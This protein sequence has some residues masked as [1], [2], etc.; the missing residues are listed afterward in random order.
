MNATGTYYTYM[1]M[2]QDDVMFTQ[3][4]AEETQQ[5]DTNDNT[6]TEQNVTF[7]IDTLTTSS[8]VSIVQANEVSIKSRGFFHLTDYLDTN[9]LD[10]VYTFEIEQDYKRGAQIEFR[11]HNFQPLRLSRY[12]NSSL[13]I[14]NYHF[15][16]DDTSLTKQSDSIENLSQFPRFVKYTVVDSSTVPSVSPSPVYNG[17]NDIKIEFFYDT[18]YSQPCFHT[19]AGYC[20]SQT[21]FDS[22]LSDFMI[23]SFISRTSLKDLTKIPPVIV[24]IQ[25]TLP[26]VVS[27]PA[28]SVMVQRRVKDNTPFFAS[29]LHKVITNVPIYL[30][31]GILYGLDETT[32]YNKLNVSNLKENRYAYLHVVSLDTLWSDQDGWETLPAGSCKVDNTNVSVTRKLISPYQSEIHFP[33]EI[34][35]FAV[36]IND[37]EYTENAP[38]VPTVTVDSVAFSESVLTYSASVSATDQYSSNDITMY[39]VVSTNPELPV[40]KLL[41]YTHSNTYESA[42]VSRQVSNGS[43]TFAGLT[44]SHVLDSADTVN[45]ISKV[46]SFTVYIYAVDALGLSTI[47]KETVHATKNVLVFQPH[48]TFKASTSS[49]TQISSVSISDNSAFT[50]VTKFK[51]KPELNFS[52]NTQIDLQLFEGD[53]Y[54]YSMCLNNGQLSLK[55]NTAYSSA[56][57]VNANT[58]YTVVVTFA[59]NKPVK[60]F[61]NDTELG[62][63]AVNVTTNPGNSDIKLTKML[64]NNSFV[65]EFDYIVGF[66]G[67]LEIPESQ[68]L[69]IEHFMETTPAAFA[70][71]FNNDLSDSKNALPNLNVSGVPTFNSASVYTNVAVTDSYKVNITNTSFVYSTNTFNVTGTVYSSD[72]DIKEYHMAIIPVNSFSDDYVTNKMINN[73]Y[74]SSVYK[75][76]VNVPKY[77]VHN[78]EQSMNF[79]LSNLQN[80]ESGAFSNDYYS[81]GNYTLAIVIVGESEKRLKRVALPHM[82]SAAEQVQQGKYNNVNG[83]ELNAFVQDFVLDNHKQEEGNVSSI[84]NQSN[85]TAFVGDSTVSVD[86]DGFT[87]TTFNQPFPLENS[88]QIPFT[89]DANNGFTVGMVIEV[90]N[91]NTGNVVEFDNQINLGFGGDQLKWSMMTDSAIDLPAEAYSQKLIVLWRVEQGTV[92]NKQK[93]I[94]KWINNSTTYR[95]VTS[96][97]TWTSS[98][99]IA[100]VNSY[101][102]TNNNYKLYEFRFVPA[103]VDDIDLENMETYFSN[104]YYSRNW[105]DVIG[106]W[107]LNEQTGLRDISGNDR[108]FRVPS[109]AAYS[110]VQNLFT[111]H[112]NRSCIDFGR[113]ARSGNVVFPSGNYVYNKLSNGEQW[114]NIVEGSNAFTLTFWWSVDSMNDASNTPF[115]NWGQGTNHVIKLDNSEKDGDLLLNGEYPFGQSAST[116]KTNGVWQHYAI[117]WNG[118]TTELYIDGVKGSSISSAIGSLDLAADLDALTL[119]ADLTATGPLSAL[120]SQTADI[121]NTVA[122]NSTSNARYSDIRLFRSAK[123]QEEIQSIYGHTSVLPRV[124]TLTTEIQPSYLA[125]TDAT[126]K[127]ASTTGV[128][129]YYL[130]AVNNWLF[131]P[132]ETEVKHFVHALPS[133]TSPGLKSDNTVYF[134][135]ASVSANTTHTVAPFMLTKAF[136]SFSGFESTENVSNVPGMYTTYLVSV[137]NNNE[138]LVTSSAVSNESGYLSAQLQMSAPTDSGLY[139][140]QG[141]ITNTT[142]VAVP[143]NYL[144][145]MQQGSSTVNNDVLALVKRINSQQY[146]LSSEVMHT[147]KPVSAG[148]T[149]VVPGGI[150]LKTAF[151]TADS[152]TETVIV[153]TETYTTYLVMVDRFGRVTVK[154]DIGVLNEN[155]NVELSI[156]HYPATNTGIFVNNSSTIIN[157]SNLPVAKYYVFA[158]DTSTSVPDEAQIKTFVQTQLSSVTSSSDTV[159]FNDTM[160]NVNDTHN[161]S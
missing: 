51:T 42:V 111:T 77:T 151:V 46:D 97:D 22:N 43:Q 93:G 58:W 106:L 24:D 101:R 138:L 98:D 117:V 124:H 147:L 8:K 4:I 79:V 132:S 84:A 57:Y 14:Q 105:S 108:H 60:A 82:M 28:Y 92:E 139:T 148:E 31:N 112:N 156:G 102:F 15:E 59:E 90:E 34:K 136:T 104:K 52:N 123:T 67:E 145:A 71:L 9:D 26:T 70:Y 2:I 80:N 12:N 99:S 49:T 19:Y 10:T 78:V 30:K 35:N 29:S 154:Q 73:H 161:V 155:P 143:V 160:I 74:L 133:Y 96:N 119:N 62:H 125:V 88:P 5:A 85:E 55:A 76:T 157:A 54:S 100:G 118:T 39:T 75:T 53:S 66:G 153:P 17:F 61:I 129:K 109:N 27:T 114:S 38:K 21:V 7:D 137:D 64:V 127:S 146:Y 36:I 135:N 72:F 116:V 144:F 44:V 131:N 68:S 128:S 20:T 122:G 45:D 56:Y 1:V 23:T 18:N 150:N 83:L 113:T 3:S 121:Q 126:I 95:K 149:L 37:V 152:F 25:N 140:I 94:V 65:N 159:L 16:T 13:H 86:S 110:S 41:Q 6:F 33:N 134:S 48:S 50:L 142:S 120:V 115:V 103:F 107:P 158:M 81:E 87:F 141:S 63:N 40:S 11:F 89:T 47:E 130:F 69:D 32:L 91:G